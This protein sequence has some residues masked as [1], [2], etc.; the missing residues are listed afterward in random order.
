MRFD[1]LIREA[2]P[3]DA[4]A[5]AEV[6]VRGWRWGYR[7]LLPGAVLAALS[8]DD[9]E[10]QWVATLA[11]PKEDSAVFVAEPGGRVAGFAHIGPSGNQ[12]VPPGTAELHG[13]DVD[14]EVAGTG[15][16]RSLLDAAVEH[17][18]ARGFEL[19]T[20]WTL[21]G[22]RRARRFYEAA[23][24]RLDG[25]KQADLHPLVLVVMHEVRYRLGLRDASV[26]RDV[27]TYQ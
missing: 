1:A 16:G 18:R 27:T 22:N 19:L 14:E 5:I 9:R 24:F 23:G 7:E 25:A 10:R 4:R 6:H 15:I 17:A 20:A 12:D 3:Q 13:L 26:E 2:K 21:E 11:K 8:V